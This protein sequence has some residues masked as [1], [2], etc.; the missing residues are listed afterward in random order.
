[1]DNQNIIQWKSTNPKGERSS[2]KKMVDF[3]DEML[4]NDVKHYAIVKPNTPVDSSVVR[5][6]GENRGKG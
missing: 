3:L 4:I 5:L 2:Y 1:M 6:A